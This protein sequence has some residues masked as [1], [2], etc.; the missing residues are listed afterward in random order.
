MP[1]PGPRSAAFLNGKAAY[2]AFASGYTYRVSAL[3]RE[4][5][6]IAAVTAR[7]CLPIPVPGRIDRHHRGRG[8]ERSSVKHYGHFDAPSLSIMAAACSVYSSLAIFPFFSSPLSS[9]TMQ[10]SCSGSGSALR[11][12]ASRDRCKHP[13]PDQRRIR[14]CCQK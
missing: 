3:A 9:S 10:R 1:H 5:A 11:R 8:M 4:E 7:W 6:P 2:G 14:R 12:P 13:S